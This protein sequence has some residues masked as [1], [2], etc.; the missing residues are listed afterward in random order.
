MGEVLLGAWYNRLSLRPVAFVQLV[1]YHDSTTST[2]PHPLDAFPLHLHHL[3]LAMAAIIPRYRR[4]DP[5]E[6]RQFNEW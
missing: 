3:S 6:A 1:T 4:L 2:E 5:T